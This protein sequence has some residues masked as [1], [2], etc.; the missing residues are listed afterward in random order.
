VLATMVDKVVA[1]ESEVSVDDEL[2]LI[3]RRMGHYSFSILEH[4]YP[5]KYEKTYDIETYV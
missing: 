1:G 4:L 3:H 2:F 5:L